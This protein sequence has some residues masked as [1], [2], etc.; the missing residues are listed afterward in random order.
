[1]LINLAGLTKG[2]LYG[3]QHCD[4]SRTTVRPEMPH[5]VV[6]SYKKSGELV[7]VQV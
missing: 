2:I 3:Y 4:D 6:G 1:M 7:K 5:A